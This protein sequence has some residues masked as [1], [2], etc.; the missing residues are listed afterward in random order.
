MKIRKPCKASKVSYW[1]GAILQTGQPTVCSIKVLC[2]LSFCFVHFLILM[3]CIIRW[4]LN[5]Y[6]YSIL[7]SSFDQVGGFGN[8]VSSGSLL[9]FS[10]IL[11]QCCTESQNDES[12]RIIMHKHSIIMIA[13]PCH[14]S[15]YSA[16]H[17]KFV[18]CK[19]EPNS[20]FVRD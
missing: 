12:S 20:R 7:Y 15:G 1:N 18:L 8:C 5:K 2:S 9:S 13:S 14:T 17:S 3:Q 10:W 4:P 6:W 16:R 19:F 11:R